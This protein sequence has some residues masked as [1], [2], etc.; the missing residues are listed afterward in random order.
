MG[1]STYLGAGNEAGVCDLINATSGVGASNKVVPLPILTVL[2]FAS[3]RGI[4]TNIE[5]V[6]KASGVEYRGLRSLCLGFIDMVWGVGVNR[7]FDITDP[8]ISG[9]GGFL[10]S[11]VMGGVMSSQDKDDLMGLGT[12]PSSR[13]EVLFGNGVVIRGQDVSFAL[14]GT[15]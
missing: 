15:K 12:Y 4:R 5:D 1:Y 9:A 13:A 10:D 8:A 7:V 3:S 6:S 14:R 11:F 2:Q